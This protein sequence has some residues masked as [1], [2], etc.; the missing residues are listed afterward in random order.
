MCWNC[1][2]ANHLDL[3]ENP[4]R[5]GLADA[6][7]RDER[8]LLAYLEPD[9][10]PYF[11][12]TG[13]AGNAR[14]PVIVSYNFVDTGDLPPV[15]G[16]HGERSY[17]A[18]SA[19]QQANFRLALQEVSKVSGVVFVETQGTAMIDAFGS[20]G[21]S[22]GGWA[23]FANSGPW[24]TG[25]G[26]LVVNDSTSFAK[27]SSAFQILLHELGHAMGL[28]HP[29]QGQNLLDPRIDNTGTTVMSYDHT[30]LRRDFAAM[31]IAALRHLY[32]H[33]IDTAGWDLKVQD[34]ILVANGSARADLMTGIGLEN[35][36][37]GLGGNDVLRGRQGEDSL[38]GGAGQDRLEGGYGADR[39]DGGLG[40]DRLVGAPA[41]EV[42]YSGA[43]PDALDVLIGGGGNDTL[44]AGN[45]R[46][47]L[48]G[49]DG[50]DLLRS[51]PDTGYSDYD[52][53]FGG[54][55]ND[56]LMGSS[57]GDTLSGGVG[58]DRITTGLAQAA[59]GGAG[60]DRLFGGAG[61]NLLTGGDGKDSLTGGGGDDDLRGGA[62]NDLG[63][64]G[65]GADTL[66]GFEGNDRLFGEGGNDWLEGGTGFDTLSGGAD[67]DWLDGGLG[68]GLLRGG[69][70][71]DTLWAGDGAS[72]LYGE[73]G[74]DALGSSSLS[75]DLLSGGTGNDT[76][77]GNAGDSLSGGDGND[78]LNGMGG[79]RLT[80]GAGADTFA[81]NVNTD[82]ALVRVMDFDAS[83]DDLTIDIGAWQWGNVLDRIS[84]FAAEGGH[85]TRAVVHLQDN[86]NTAAILFVG[87]T[88]DQLNQGMFEIT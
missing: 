85:S 4:E 29:F 49:G 21:S 84:F 7:L 19:L 41:D 67:H 31:D 57:Y 6:V 73:A 77:S 1:L 27:G 72:R 79:G 5:I 64:G 48:E 23:N 9:F 30:V 58:N 12:W 13:F 40:D 83:L 32:G 25:E 68:G 22:F 52:G 11:S 28:K 36:I 44:I 42:V 24:H 87:V 86:S 61:N 26:I 34:N 60:D 45:R 8:A 15:D 54:A 50:N 65:A 80:G 10:S 56:T 62:G 88:P 14:M 38:F 76:L 75:D 43:N 71:D 81:F 69:G 20:T 63:R 82:P 70:G 66:D 17:F 3:P 37:S 78:L 59:D 53:L 51:S 46:A 55:G 47:S 33:S 39:L 35:R 18:F 16:A 2:Q 74:Q